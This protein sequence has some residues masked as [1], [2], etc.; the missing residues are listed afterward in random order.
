MCIS[1]GRGVQ[2]SIFLDEKFLLYNKLFLIL[3]NKT[4][5]KYFQRQLNNYP[6]FPSTDLNS[7]F[8]V[9]QIKADLRVSALL[10]SSTLLSLLI[11]THS[12]ISP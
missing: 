3:E 7:P 9:M 5:T 6:V 2:I 4:K 1:C 10:N 8:L 12:Y 11:R